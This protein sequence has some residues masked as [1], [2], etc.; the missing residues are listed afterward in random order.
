MA[1]SLYGNRDRHDYSR[2]NF[3]A[4]TTL[5]FDHLLELRDSELSNQPDALL[6]QFRLIFASGLGGHALQVTQAMDNL[7]RSPWIEDEFRHILNRCSYILINHWLLSP[8][9]RT[10]VM[11]LVKLLA[12]TAEESGQAQKARQLRRLLK[13]FTASEHFKSLERRAYAAQNNEDHYLRSLIHRYPNLY[14]HYLLDV[15]NSSLETTDH[16]SKSIRTLQEEREQQFELALWQFQRGTSV[17]GQVFQNPTQLAELEL[18]QSIAQFTGP[19]ERDRS[20]R[21]LASEFLSV[22]DRCRTFKEVKHCLYDYVNDSFTATG[23]GSYAQRF[24]PWL[25]QQLRRSS[26]ANDNH[27]PTDFLIRRTCSDLLDTLVADPSKA[28]KD[29]AQFINMVDNLGASFVVGLVVK[30]MLLA[31]RINQMVSVLRTSVSKRL[32]NVF[33][34]Y[35]SHQSQDLQ[36]FVNCLDHW[37]VANAVQFS[38]RDPNGWLLIQRTQRI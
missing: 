23:N 2:Q 36:W 19:V 5:L 13:K 1:T 20:Y 27:A 11:K 22:S 3:E 7:L 37:M 32:A 24:T 34:H 10:Y 26:P 28:P 21:Q 6:E 18:R 14:P 29:H 25:E 8:K 16:S 17:T 12:Q 4:D 15:T 31:Q 9:Q 33:K 38:D 30:I 35:E